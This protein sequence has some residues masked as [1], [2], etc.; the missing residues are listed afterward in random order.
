M[1][2]RHQPSE[3]KTGHCPP[4]NRRTVSGNHSSGPTAPVI[5]RLPDTTIPIDR[6]GQRFS[7]TRFWLTGATTS[8]V[9]T[10]HA[11]A[12][13]R[14]AKNALHYGKLS[15]GQGHGTMAHAVQQASDCALWE[16]VTR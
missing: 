16:V 12:T 2:S 10:A 7:P 1:V 6:S 3:R 9:P 11:R 5:A 15:G 13:R 14:Q 4:Y 8:S